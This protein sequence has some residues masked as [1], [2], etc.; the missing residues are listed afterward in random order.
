MPASIVPTQTVL[1]TKMMTLSP[2]RRRSSIIH[3][4]GYAPRRE[5]EQSL[6]M[7]R[8]PR[9]LGRTRNKE[10]SATTTDRLH[11]THRFPYELNFIGCQWLN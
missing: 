4:T 9:K 2:S 8:A 10:L 7:R 5:D 6:Q 3:K 11:L 1:T